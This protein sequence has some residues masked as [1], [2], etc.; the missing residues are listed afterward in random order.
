MKSDERFV[1]E[2]MQ[3][4]RRMLENGKVEGEEGEELRGV[5]L[6]VKGWITSNQKTLAFEANGVIKASLN[7]IKGIK[8]S[9]VYSFNFIF[10]L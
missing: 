1:S 6:R 10:R 5:I 4:L 9:F 8:T 7:L 3:V 2:M